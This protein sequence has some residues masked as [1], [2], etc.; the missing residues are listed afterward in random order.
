MDCS[1][2][3]PGGWYLCLGGGRCAASEESEYDTRSG[4]RLDTMS[5]FVQPPPVRNLLLLHLSHLN[6]DLHLRRHPVHPRLDNGIVQALPAGF[7]SAIPWLRTGF[8]L[9]GSRPS[10]HWYSYSISERTRQ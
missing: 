9:G 10:T 6:L 8:D 2:Q 7:P 3:S 5:F 4:K 1:S